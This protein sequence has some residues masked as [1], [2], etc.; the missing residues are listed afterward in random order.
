MWRFLSGVSEPPAKKKKKSEEE[1]KQQNKKYEEEKR[2]R[3]W[4]PGWKKTD[5]GEERAW[6]VYKDDKKEMHCAPCRKWVTTYKQQQ[7]PF[8]I[9]TNLFKLD[10]IKKTRAVS[11]TQRLLP[12]GKQMKKNCW[13]V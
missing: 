8:V 12:E 3:K 4:V 11:W 9:G 1:K 5:T 10:S 6:L 13:R 7:Q 2:D